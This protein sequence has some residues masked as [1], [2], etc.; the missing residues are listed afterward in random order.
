MATRSESRGEVDR[1]GGLTAAALLVDDRDGAH[2]VCPFVRDGVLS[3][4]NPCQVPA[5][6]SVGSARPNDVRID[7]GSEKNLLIDAIGVH[8]GKA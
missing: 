2:G 6:N 5:L 8:R 7:V 4:S 1:H 3:R